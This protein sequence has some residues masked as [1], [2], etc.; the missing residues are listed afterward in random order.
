MNNKVKKE[1]RGCFYHRPIIHFILEIIIVVIVAYIASGGTISG[2]V[3]F[4]TIVIG[5]GYSILK[6]P[7]FINRVKHC[8]ELEKRI[9]K[10]A[11]EDEELDEILDFI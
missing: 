10:R 2:N 11:E 9:R 8:K 4:I 3:G 6:L 5:A 7:A 1:R